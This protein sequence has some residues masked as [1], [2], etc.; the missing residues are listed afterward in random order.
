M[1]AKKIFA[2]LLLTMIFAAG[3]LADRGEQTRVTN[4]AIVYK[5]ACFVVTWDTN[6]TADYA[7]A[8]FN[9]YQVT[10]SSSNAAWDGYDVNIES[11]GTKLLNLCTVSPG[12][13]ATAVIKRFD[14]N[15]LGGQFSEGVL[16]ETGTGAAVD[17]AGDANASITQPNTT[18]A[19][20]Y[21][22]YQVLA[23][24]AGLVVLIIKIGRAHV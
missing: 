14:G 24:I 5:N 3:V 10:I 8:D 15:K 21:L 6:N 19:G 2:I 4:P 23:G 11:V 1:N 13:T 20:L 7:A 12:D 22:F 16:G 17:G 18:Q 9:N